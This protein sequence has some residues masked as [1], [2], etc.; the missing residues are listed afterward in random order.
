MADIVITEADRGRDMAA[1]VGDTLVVQ[2]RENPTTGYRWACTALDAN[3]LE[4]AGDDFGTGGQA[5]V[6]G[7]GLRVFRF[8]AKG[9]GSARVEFKLARSWESGAPSALFEFRVSVS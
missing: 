5:G 9:G 7:G 6:G 4:L 2:L 1:Q 3:I 8:G